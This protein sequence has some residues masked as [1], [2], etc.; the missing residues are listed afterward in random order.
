M[1][2][3]GVLRQTLAHAFSEIDTLDC[4]VAR[5]RARRSL[6]YL[7]SVMH[8]DD[9]AR[10]LDLEPHDFLDQHDGNAVRNEPPH[11]FHDLVDFLGVE[12]A[13]WFIH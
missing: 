7:L 5:K 4:L 2:I 13:H 1:R 12:A 6:E 11:Q 9:A 3:R 8:D 10:Q